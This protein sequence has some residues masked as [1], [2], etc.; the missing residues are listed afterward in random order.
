MHW[1]PQEIAQ[2]TAFFKVQWSDF[3]LLLKSMDEAG[4]GKAVLLYPTSDAHL[5]MG[6]WQNVCEVYN[7]EIAKKVKEN[8]ER[9]W[10]AGIL[11][12]DEESKIPAELNRIKNLGLKAISL[13]SSYEGNFLDNE[14]FFPIFE[15]CSRE[16]FPIFVH[17]Q[18]INPIGFERVDDPLITPVV[19]Y[20]FDMTVSVAK[21]MMSGIFNK[22]P[23]VK[24]VFGHFAGVIPFIKDRFDATYQM[25]RQR[26]IVKDIGALPSEIFKKIYV[27]TSGVKSVSMLNMALETF[28]PDKILWGS[29]FP[30]KRDLKESIE[31]INKLNLR[32]EEKQG[33]LG[34]NLGK[35]FG[36]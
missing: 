14:I 32:E 18:I 15:F 11:P 36:R 29:D 34:G 4:I 12:I 23:Q 30:A 9:F 3:D 16:N 6:G 20:V 24:F 28:S 1:M 19:E 17:S 5:K 31:T 25:L 21:L 2:N 22:F 27:D 7:A 10:G 33:I 13:A 35:I 8:K 26:Q